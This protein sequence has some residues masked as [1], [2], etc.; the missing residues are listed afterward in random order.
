MWLQHSV[1]PSYLHQIQC[2]SRKWAII[3]LEIVVIF[4][5][6]EK[7]TPGNEKHGTHRKMVSSENHRLKS[8][9]WGKDFFV[10]SQ[11]WYTLPKTNKSHR[12]ISGT[13][14]SRHLPC[15]ERITSPTQ[16]C[17]Q[18]GDMLV[19]KGCMIEI[20]VD[21]DISWYLQASNDPTSIVNQWT[22]TFDTTW[23]KKTPFT[24]C[25]LSAFHRTC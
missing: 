12:T 22:M 17:R 13:H 5:K 4:R 19:A 3:F 10:S 8:A 2:H 1:A 21:I 25:I 6:I 18:G 9:F 11:D 24:A 14:S 16:N 23:G 15:R 20:F 7:K